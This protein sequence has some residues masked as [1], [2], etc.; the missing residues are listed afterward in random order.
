MCTGSEQLHLGDQTVELP[1]KKA[2]RCVSDNVRHCVRQAMQGMD[3]TKSVEAFV[4]SMWRWFVYAGQ[5]AMKWV[6]VSHA[7]LQDGHVRW[8]CGTLTEA[9]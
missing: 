7:L 8:A 2:T 9:W 6:V 3:E 5:S 1:R 4:I